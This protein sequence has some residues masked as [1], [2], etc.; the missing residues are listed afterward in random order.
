MVSK[1]VDRLRHLRSLRGLT[2]EGLASQINCTREAIASYE[3]GKTTPPLEVLVQLADYFHISLDYLVG[4]SDFP[5]QIYR[6]AVGEKDANLFQQLYRLS[7]QDREKI[8]SIAKIFQEED[9]E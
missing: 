2:Q 8:S 9:S 7:P 1:M 6:D 5:N 4:R 3:T